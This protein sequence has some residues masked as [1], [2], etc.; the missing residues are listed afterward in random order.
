MHRSVAA[1]QPAIRESIDQHNVTAR[2]F[3][4]TKTADEILPSI[5]PACEA[6]ARSPRRREQYFANQMT[7]DTRSLEPA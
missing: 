5:C 1:P 4:W 6:D 3:L 7:Q 2:P